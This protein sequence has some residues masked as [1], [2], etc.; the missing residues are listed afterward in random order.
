MSGIFRYGL[1][2]VMAFVSM[3]HVYS[4]PNLNFS[5][6][7]TSTAGAFADVIWFTLFGIIALAAI[8]MRNS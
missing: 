8:R 6:Y 7:E 4:L 2:I 1:V 3:S 5:G